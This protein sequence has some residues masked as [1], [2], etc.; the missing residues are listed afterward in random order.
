MPANKSIVKI[1]PLVTTIILIA[2]V[3]FSAPNPMPAPVQPTDASPPPTDTPTSAPLTLTPP[4]PSPRPT[5]TPTPAPEWVTN[6]AE[7]ILAETASRPPD[8]E[9]NFGW[10]TDA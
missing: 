9:D 7:P 8:I 3:L 1:Y 10:A 6:F 2:C 4:P 5:I